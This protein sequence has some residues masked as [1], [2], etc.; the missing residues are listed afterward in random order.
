MAL[1]LQNLSMD[2]WPNA[3]ATTKNA[4][5]PRSIRSITNRFPPS[6]GG[7]GKART[8]AAGFSNSITNGQYLNAACQNDKPY[9]GLP[10]AD[11]GEPIHQRPNRFPA[12]RSPACMAIEGA[13]WLSE[14][15]LFQ[16]QGVSQHGLQFARPQPACP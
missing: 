16:Q 11:H 2:L 10:L 3:A 8:G 13:S 5:F 6:D 12:Y 7:I 9:P 14:E 1:V 15:I 4:V